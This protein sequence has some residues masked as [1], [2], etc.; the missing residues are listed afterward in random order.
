MNAMEE[1]TKEQLQTIKSLAAL[2]YTITQIALMLEIQV[3]SFRK[4]MMNIDSEIYKA[5]TSGKLESQINY[6][7]TVKKLAES[8]EPWAIHLIEKWDIAQNE[9][10]LGCH[11]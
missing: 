6:R 9:E 3:S 10:E 4:E 7:N 5:Y 2:R 1:L 11:S 8:G